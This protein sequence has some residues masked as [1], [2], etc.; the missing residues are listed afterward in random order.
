MAANNFTYVIIGGGLAG[1]SAITGIREID[2]NGSLLLVGRE[3]HLPYDRPPLSKKLWSGKKKVEE[4]FV[5]SEEYYDQ[6]GV[7]VLRGNTVQVVDPQ[8]STIT[9][10]TGQTF[11][12]KKLLLATGAT[13]RNLSIPGSDMDGLCYFRNLEDYLNCRS[14]ALEG[15]SAVVIGGGFMGSEIAAA[16]SI[17][18]LKVTMIFPGPYLCS[19]IFPRDLGSALQ[20]RYEERGVVVVAEDTPMAFEKNGEGFI[21][22]TEKGKRILSDLVVIGV[23]VE[24]EQ[25]LATAAGIKTG[26]GIIVNG[27]LETSYPGIYAAGDNARFPYQALGKSMRIEHW[28]N[29]LNQGRLA[30]RN[31]AGASESY[32]YMPYFFSDLFEFGYEAVGDIDSTLEIYAD[33]EKENDT[34]ILYYLKDNIV[35]GVL[36][37]N[38]WDKIPA[39]RELIRKADQ[40]SRQ[41]LTGTIR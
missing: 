5:H 14:R 11:G 41:S 7:T 12:F 10:A 26:N 4:L 17:N 30:G 19:R 24:P 16:L 32:T 27:Y 8:R 25:R 40:V 22:V 21:T 13:P 31:M 34:G 23:G 36:M 3:P 39:A 29:A 28:D 35:R 15:R 20:R 38:V 33:W 37:G 6:N 2:K 1:A 9:D 18:A